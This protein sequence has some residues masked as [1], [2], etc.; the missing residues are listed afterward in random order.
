MRVCVSLK[1]H[2]ALRGDAERQKWP[3]AVPR[4]QSW[5]G[6]CVRPLFPISLAGNASLL[7]S[8]GSLSLSRYPTRGK[9]GSAGKRFTTRGETEDGEGFPSYGGAPLD[10]LR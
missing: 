8:A 10:A 3:E 5:G 6:R 1:D 4:R 9:E 2:G 7:L